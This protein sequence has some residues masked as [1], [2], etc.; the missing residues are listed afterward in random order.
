[1][2]VGY[3]AFA[4]LTSARRLGLLGE[5]TPTDLSYLST[6]L[7]A[8]PKGLGHEFAEGIYQFKGAMSLIGGGRHD[9]EVRDV[10]HELPD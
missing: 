4:K 7:P 5:S 1:L 2:P 10:V 3:V 6:C 9:E 8:A